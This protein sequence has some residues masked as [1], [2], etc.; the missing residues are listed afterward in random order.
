[1]HVCERFCNGT[2]RSRDRRCIA[3]VQDCEGAF[4]NLFTNTIGK[5]DELLCH[6]FVHLALFAERSI[7]SP[8]SLDLRIRL[9]RENFDI[10]DQHGGSD[11]GRA[12][13]R[14][15]FDR[16]S[17]Q[18]PSRGD[19]VGEGLVKPLKGGKRTFEPRVGSGMALGEVI[20]NGIERG[21]RLLWRGIG[22]GNVVRWKWE[23][24]F[25]G[26]RPEFRDSRIGE[27]CD[28]LGWIGRAKIAQWSRMFQKEIYVALQAEKIR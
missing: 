12:R 13:L 16:G 21:K 11:L 4:L 18:L 17:D 20:A 19:F 22:I 6:P 1:L 3:S 28:L 7:A 23:I 14:P 2:V 9:R 24:E 27:G 5:P 15:P 25:G 26:F 10:A 8:D